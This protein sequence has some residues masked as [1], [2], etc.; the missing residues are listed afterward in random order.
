MPITKENL[1]EF[2]EW[3]MNN[4]FVMQEERTVA[5]ELVKEYLDYLDNK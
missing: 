5:V 1:R 4:S 3:L 2:D